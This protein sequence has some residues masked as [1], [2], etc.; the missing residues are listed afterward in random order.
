[1]KTGREGGVGGGGGMFRA[2]LGG[3]WSRRVGCG[4]CKADG[5]QFVLLLRVAAAAGTP[6]VCAGSRLHSRLCPVR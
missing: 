1:L 5:V 2:G 3:S 4:S 6:H